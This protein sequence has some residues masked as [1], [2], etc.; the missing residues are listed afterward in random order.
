MFNQYRTEIIEYVK[1]TR[2][3]W[4]TEGGI[5]EDWDGFVKK[6]DDMGLQKVMDVYQSGYDDFYSK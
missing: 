3:K 1:T 4:I 2:A 6:L 5:E